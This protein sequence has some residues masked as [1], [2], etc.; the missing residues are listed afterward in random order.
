ML[1]VLVPSVF[2]VSNT[3]HPTHLMHLILRPH[4]P[5][6]DTHLLDQQVSL[7]RKHDVLG[8]VSSNSASLAER[9]SSLGTACLS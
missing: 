8:H 4:L 5:P 2:F 9:L 7:I 6:V 1:L 3:D